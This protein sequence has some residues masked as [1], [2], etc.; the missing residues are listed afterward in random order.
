MGQQLQCNIT[1]T[2]AP[3]NK[4]R[5]GLERICRTLVS[6]TP[7]V[8][9]ARRP[10]ASWAF[11]CTFNSDNQRDSRPCLNPY[12]VITTCCGRSWHIRPPLLLWTHVS[13]YL[14]HHEAQIKLE[15]GNKHWMYPSVCCEVRAGSASLI[16]WPQGRFLRKVGILNTNVLCL[17]LCCTFTMCHST[18]FA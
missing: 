15:K 4:D 5:Q 1:P 14:L 12:M 13:A 9:H 8:Y 11:K 2:L 7:Y 16:E 3:N 6:I 17:M 18:S 10:S